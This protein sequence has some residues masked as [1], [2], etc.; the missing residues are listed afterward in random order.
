[1][2][3]LS[4]ATFSIYTSEAGSSIICKRNFRLHNGAYFI[5]IRRNVIQ[6][7][8]KIQFDYF[9]DLLFLYIFTFFQMYLRCKVGWAASS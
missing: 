1:M 7:L 4:G 3:G 9:N 8:I 6:S 2:M 5:I